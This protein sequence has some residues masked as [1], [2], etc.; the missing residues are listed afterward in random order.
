MLGGH[1]RR[2]DEGVTN[3]VSGL[4]D[5]MKPADAAETLLPTQMAAPH[6]AT[7]MPAR[8]S[9]HVEISAQRDAA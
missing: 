5:A 9:N 7:M 8:R 4:V 1:G 6:Q 3:F 2:I